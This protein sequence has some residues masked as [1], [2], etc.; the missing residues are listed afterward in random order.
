[1]RKLTEERGYKRCNDRAN[2]ELRGQAD[3]KIDDRMKLAKS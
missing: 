3:V 1:M 2:A